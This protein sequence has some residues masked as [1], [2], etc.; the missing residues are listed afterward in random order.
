M[1]LSRTRRIIEECFLWANQREV[2]GKKLIEQPVIRNHL[3]DMLSDY[4]AAYSLYEK[5]TQQYMTL[6]KNQVNEKIG[7]PQAL[8]KYRCTRMS[9]N[10]ADRAV[11]IFGGRAVTKTG[12]GKSVS[13]CVAMFCVAVGVLTCKNAAQLSKELQARVSLRRFGGN[14]G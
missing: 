1:V 6:P 10:V 13:R 14:H 8:L 11:Q 5:T 12:M 4:Q 7:G 2:F 3:A 9:T